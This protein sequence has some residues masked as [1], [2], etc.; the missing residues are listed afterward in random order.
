MPFFII[1][2]K[3][4]IKNQ[5]RNNMN[6]WCD[7]KDDVADGEKIY[8]CTKC[9]KRLHPRKLF[10]EDG[11]FAGWQLPPHKEKGHKIRAL[12]KQRPKK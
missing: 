7:Q 10:N 11:E 3:K 2:I 4:Y 6:D 12:R 1:F 9:G 8:R 5:K